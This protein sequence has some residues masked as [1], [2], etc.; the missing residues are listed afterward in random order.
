MQIIGLQITLIVAGISILF[1]RNAELKGFKEFIFLMP[2]FAFAYL[3]FKEPEFIEE[4][5]V[6]FFSIFIC[7]SMAIIWKTNSIK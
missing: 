6:V 3:F 5:H 2:V 7:I 1:I 4:K